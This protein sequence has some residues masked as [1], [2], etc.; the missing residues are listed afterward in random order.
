MTVLAHNKGTSNRPPWEEVRTFT[1]EKLL[2]TQ[3]LIHPHTLTNAQMTAQ[4]LR[5]L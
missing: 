5:Q 3:T 1:N 4:T 2:H